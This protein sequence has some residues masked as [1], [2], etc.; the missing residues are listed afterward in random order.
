MRFDVRDAT[1]ADAAAISAVEVASWNA[2]Y[3]GLLPDSYLDRVSE[4]EGTLRW[5]R[6]IS[7]AEERRRPILVAADAGGILAGYAVAGADPDDGAMGLLFLLYTAPAA[8]GTGAGSLLMEAALQRLRDMRFSEA[9][10]WV[11]EA[12]ARARAFYHREGWRP[13]GATST[14]TFD[15]IAFPALRYTRTLKA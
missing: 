11:L 1:L 3:R 6:A 12:N 8:W 4:S 10:L 2:A 15:G 5:R 14:S 9:R 13:D 7:L